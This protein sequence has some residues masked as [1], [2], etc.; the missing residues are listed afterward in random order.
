M[1]EEHSSGKDCHSDCNHAQDAA[2]SRDIDD[3]HCD[4]DD[5]EDGEVREG[6][7]PL[8]GVPFSERGDDCVNQGV[9]EKRRNLYIVA[10]KS[11][12]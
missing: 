10:V 12:L 11:C 3:K 4:R 9:S 6:L 7:C 1:L 2:A 8:R 5:Y